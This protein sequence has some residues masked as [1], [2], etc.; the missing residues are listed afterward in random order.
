MEKVE[1]N[2]ILCQKHKLYTVRVQKA[3]LSAFDDKR[4]IDNDGINTY[5]WG[6][7]DIRKNTSSV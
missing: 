3:G 6:H 2:K 7:K 5:A 4:Y 1:F